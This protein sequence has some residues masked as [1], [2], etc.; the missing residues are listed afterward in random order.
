VKSL[1]NQLDQSDKAA[2]GIPVNDRLQFGW[3]KTQPVYF[4]NALIRLTILFHI[5][6]SNLTFVLCTAP[7]NRRLAVVGGA[8]LGHG[9]GGIVLSRAA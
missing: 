3:L 7:R 6:T 5:E 8:I 9:S 1:T 4:A 2:L